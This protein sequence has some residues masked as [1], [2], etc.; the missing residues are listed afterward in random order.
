MIRVLSDYFTHLFCDITNNLITGLLENSEFCPSNLNVSRY[1]VEGNIGF[2]EKQNSLFPLVPV[3]LKVLINQ[4]LGTQHL[5][6]LSF[7]AFSLLSYSIQVQPKFP[8]A[9][10]KNLISLLQGF[11]L[12]YYMRNRAFQKLS[13]HC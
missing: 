4:L 13:G 8:E 3:I 5:A 6:A 9:P 10:L 1:E 11:K 12:E 7:I 2:L